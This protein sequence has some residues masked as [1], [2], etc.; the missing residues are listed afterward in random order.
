MSFFLELVPAKAM[1]IGGPGSMK[2]RTITRSEAEMPTGSGPGPCKDG[3][4]AAQKMV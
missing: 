3:C 2:I 1:G 4:L